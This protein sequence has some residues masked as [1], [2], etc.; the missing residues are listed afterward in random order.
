MSL[1]HL[2]EGSQGLLLYCH[3]RTSQSFSFVTPET[4]PSGFRFSF[5]S[6]IPV[7]MSNTYMAGIDL[8]HCCMLLRQITSSIQTSS[9]CCRCHNQQRS[10]SILHA[11]VANHVMSICV[12]MKPD[13]HGAVC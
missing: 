10:N 3:R 2:C 13:L 1:T 11:A 4:Q 12:F 9:L 6:A 7:S 8:S 5:T